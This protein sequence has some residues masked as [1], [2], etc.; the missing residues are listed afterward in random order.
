MKMTISLRDEIAGRIIRS[1]PA[2]I[3]YESQMQEEM[4][5][6]SFNQL[7]HGLKQLIEIN[8]EAKN[9]LTVARKRVPD[10]DCLLLS[11]YAHYEISKDTHKKIFDL[12]ILHDKQR[13]SYRNMCN[14]I[15]GIVKSYKTVEQFVKDYPDFLK[16]IPSESEPMN[17][18]ATNLIEEMKKM[19]WK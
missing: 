14:Q 12:H 17:L 5:K 13:E 8:P 15:R 3:D 1:L 19:G 9:Y 2:Q 16:Y 4:W 6:D 7:P 10:C 11:C 18:P